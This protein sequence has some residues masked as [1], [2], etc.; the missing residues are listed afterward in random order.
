MSTVPF[1]LKLLIQNELT[2]EKI[3]LTQIM[4]I[5]ICKKMSLFWKFVCYNKIESTGFL[6]LWNSF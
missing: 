3:V 4:K 2:E 1:C 5:P 6:D